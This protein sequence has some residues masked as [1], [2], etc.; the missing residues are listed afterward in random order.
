VRS[1]SWAL[2]AAIQRK[3]CATGSTGS[4]LPVSAFS[5]SAASFTPSTPGA[6]PANTSTGGYRGVPGV[7]P[8]Y[9]SLSKTVTGGTGGKFEVP[10]SL[11]RSLRHATVGGCRV[12]S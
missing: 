10:S 7:N 11:Q 3:V 12:L 6:Q 8:S 1:L 9:L 2:A 5:K 4:N